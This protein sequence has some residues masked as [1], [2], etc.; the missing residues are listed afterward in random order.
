MYLYQKPELETG[1]RREELHAEARGAQKGNELGR[2]EMEVG[3]QCELTGDSSVKNRQ[4]LETGDFPPEL[5][6]RHDS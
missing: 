4:E 6:G 1:A 3:W 5:H 2:L